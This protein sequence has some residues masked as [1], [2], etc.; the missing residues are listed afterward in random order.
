MKSVLAPVR[1]VGDDDD[2]P[3]RRHRLAVAALAGELLQGGEDDAARARRELVAEI[4][5][6]LGLVRL[7]PQQVGRPAELGEELVVE[8]VAVGEHHDGRIL[9]RDLSEELADEE[10]HREALAA[11]L[12]VPDH[13]DLSVSL[14]RCRP[15]RLRN[16]LVDGEVLVV[17]G[18]FL[19]NHAVAP[20]LE[21]DERAQQVDDPVW[22]Q[23]AEHQRPQLE[24]APV[25][26]VLA[27][28]RTPRH[29]AV[30]PGGDRA[31][32]RLVGVG[33]DER[34]VV[35]HQ[36]WQVGDVGLQLVERAHHVVF[37][38]PLQL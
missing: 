7:L 11:A 13:A 35:P 22:P 17:P 8:I 6:A 18:D 31:H 1:L 9:E 29:E 28:G 37:R 33:G 23:R 38:G 34:E 30:D 15:Q 2:V 19:R 24:S 26:E 21:E 10:E 16:G 25:D 14:R 12:C 5:A 36:V 3:A 32:A 4:D 20:L 27:V